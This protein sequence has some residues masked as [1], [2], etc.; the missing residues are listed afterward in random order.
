MFGAP[1][2]GK[3]TQGQGAR[4]RAALFPLRL[5]RRVPLARHAHQARPGVSALF[6]RAANSCRRRLTIEL[7]QVQIRGRRGWPPLQAGT[8]LPRPRRH[9]A[10]RRAG[11]GDEAADRGEKGVPPHLPGP[12]R[13]RQA[14]QE[15]RP[16][17]QPPRRRQREPSSAT[18]WR[19]TRRRA[20][21]CW[22]ITGRT[23]CRPLT[24]R[25]R[26]SKFCWRSCRPSRPCSPFP[27]AYV[28]PPAR[29]ASRSSR[30]CAHRACTASSA[31][32]P[33]RCVSGC[34]SCCRT[35]KSMITCARAARVRSGN[36]K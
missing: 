14:P 31:R 34:C 4:Q 28:Q 3:G 26:R 35:R 25:S 15:T 24:P 13:T 6:Q 11:P 16:E 17:G 18:G 2:S 32:T 10:Q 33:C 12:Q 30:A 22:I 21:R 19:P 23:S 20:S 29:R 27:A 7:W 36:G 5:R 1:G 8:G 9:P